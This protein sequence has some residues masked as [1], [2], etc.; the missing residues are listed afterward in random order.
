MDAFFIFLE[1]SV[2]VDRFILAE[3]V[4]GVALEQFNR[5]I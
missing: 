3:T 4:E 5:G 2:E 1:E